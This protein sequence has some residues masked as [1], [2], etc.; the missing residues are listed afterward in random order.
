[1]SNQNREMNWDKIGVISLLIAIFG[2]FAYENIKYQ[3]AKKSKH[4][5]IATIYEIE[6]SSDAGFFISFSYKLKNAIPYEGSEPITTDTW[7]EWAYHPKVGERYYV[8]FLS[9][10]PY[11]TFLCLDRQVPDSIKEAPKEGWVGDLPCADD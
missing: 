7:G 5:T 4:Y 8:K 6:A 9:Y 11:S 1:M 2:F 10:D 3:M